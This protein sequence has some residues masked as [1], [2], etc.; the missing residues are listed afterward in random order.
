MSCAAPQ[1]TASILRYCGGSETAAAHGAEACAWMA[2]AS[3]GHLEV[4][5]WARHHCCPW[6]E[7]TCS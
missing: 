3:M 6:D 7:R 2:T 4:L 1:R 5:R